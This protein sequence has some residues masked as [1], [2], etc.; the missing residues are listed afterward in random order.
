M[1][2]NK[3]L[4]P[5]YIFETSWEVCNKVGGIYTVLSTRANTMRTLFG[6]HII[7][8]GPD[9]WKGK[10]NPDFI[11]NAALFKSWKKQIET[12]ENL[13]VRTGRWNVPGN[14][15]VILVDFQSC[16]ERKND[17]YTSMWQ[18]FGVDSL[19]AYGDY[20]E[21][22]MFACAAGLVIHNFYTFF[23]L[24]KKRVAAHFNEW[25]L[26]MGALYIQSN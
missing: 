15:V 1:T 23:D 8:I 14:P 26:G 13:P 2:T 24:G 7:F 6:D 21:S 12:T 16:F 20:D 22:C 9:L 11:E 10:D 5:D 3:R 18:Q 17:L 19:H 25:M 4:T